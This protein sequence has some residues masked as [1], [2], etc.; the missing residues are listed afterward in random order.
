MPAGIESGMHASNVAPTGRD[1]FLPRDEII[2]SKTD[3]KVKATSEAARV[4][5][6]GK[7]LLWWRRRRSKLAQADSLATGESTQ[8]IASMRTASSQTTKAI[9]QP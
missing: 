8:E 5:E 6:A 3:L 1:R 9:G 7:D 2:V 4:G